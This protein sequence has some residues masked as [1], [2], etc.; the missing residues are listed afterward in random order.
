MTIDCSLLKNRNMSNPR[1]VFFKNVPTTFGLTV[2][3]KNERVYFI[4]LVH[5][6]THQ[7]PPQCHLLFVPSSC[8]S[9]VLAW[10]SYVYQELSSSVVFALDISHGYGPSGLICISFSSYPTCDVNIFGNYSYPS[11]M[12]RFQYTVTEIGWPSNPPWPLVKPLSPSACHLSPDF[13]SSQISR[14]NLAQAIFGEYQAVL[15]LVKP[16]LF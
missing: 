13:S 2:L 11:P 4:P 8:F 1:N 16:D 14:N 3:N 5:R 6:I 7:S 10:A 12:N 9:L 15:F